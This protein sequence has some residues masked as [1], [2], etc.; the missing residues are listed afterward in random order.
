MAKA[1]MVGQC[2]IVSGL[3]GRSVGVDGFN[4]NVTLRVD[5][6]DTDEEALQLANEVL[7]HF[8]GIQADSVCVPREEWQLMRKVVESANDY[9]IGA[10][11]REF[12][13]LNGGKDTLFDAMTEHILLYQGWLSENETV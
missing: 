6:A 10:L 13:K 12:A 4:E 3:S 7:D 8:K 11:D 5:N 2:Y 1:K 9:S